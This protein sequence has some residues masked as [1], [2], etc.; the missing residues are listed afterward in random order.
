M[1]YIQ[2]PI[3]PKFT[4]DPHYFHENI[5]EYQKRPHANV[6]DMNADLIR[7]WND[8]VAPTDWT[9]VVGDVAM[10]RP[11]G[12]AEIIAALNGKKL[13][14]L[15]NHDRSASFME[16]IGFD[17]VVKNAIIEAGGIRIWANHFPPG[18][19]RQYVH[20]AKYDIA[21]CGHVH[22]KWV[23]RDGCVN[24]GVDVW[25]YTPVD[26]NRVMYKALEASI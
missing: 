22:S 20:P 11:D 12:W 25:D 18:P 14:V 7:R 24:V 17:I 8:V 4:A 9:V 15:G 13:L 23:V 26:L 5:I 3:V 21:V 1:K 10:G 2:L 19:Q 6:A 16:S